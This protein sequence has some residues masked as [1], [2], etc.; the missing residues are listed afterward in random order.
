MGLYID[1]AI[2]FALGIGG[3]IYYSIKNSR[4]IASGKRTETEGK[5]R[6][7]KIWVLCGLIVLVGVLKLTEF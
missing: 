7:K 4:E 2:P 1:T 6:L 3:L 5:S